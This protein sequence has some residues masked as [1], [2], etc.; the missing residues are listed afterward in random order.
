MKLDIEYLEKLSKKLRNTGGLILS[1]LG[2]LILL[3]AKLAGIIKKANQ[4]K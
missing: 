4:K 1:V 2:Y 3:F